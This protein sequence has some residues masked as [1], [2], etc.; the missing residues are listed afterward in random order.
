MPNRKMPN[1]KMPDRKMPDQELLSAYLDGELP[2]PVA[3]RV[4]DRLAGD[5]ALRRE[6]FGLQQVSAVLRVHCEADPGFVVRHRQR[7]EDLSPVLQWTWRQ[8]GFRLSAAAAALLVAAG[9][10][11]YQA[12][13]TGP[14]ANSGAEGL[15][16]SALEGQVLGAPEEA[17][18]LFSGLSGDGFGLQDPGASEFVS[19][20][21]TGPTEEPVLLI[22][23]GGSFPPPG[24]PGR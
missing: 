21:E 12:G 23:L 18:E 7:R 14:G 4:E 6:Y 19:V 2:P 10:S 22:A 5:P 16:L 9:V 11:L 20:M 24:G 17:A 8:L 3:Q 13:G 1:L 15:D